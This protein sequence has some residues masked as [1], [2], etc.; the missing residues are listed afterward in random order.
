[1]GFH[2]GL[3][4]AGLRL[5]HVIVFP[6]VLWETKEVTSVLASLGGRGQ[7]WCEHLCVCA[8][9]F[10]AGRGWTLHIT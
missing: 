2:R 7:I 5:H 3:G 4:L 6:L 1:M 8:C 10:T 9:V